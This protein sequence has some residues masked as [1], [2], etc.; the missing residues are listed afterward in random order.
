MADIREIPTS[1]RQ[2]LA[3]LLQGHSAADAM[4]AYYALEHPENKVR[5]FTYTS[6]KG[7]PR[8]FLALAKTGLDL[9]RPLLVPFV[10][11]REMLIELLREVLEPGQPFVLSLPAEQLAWLGDH[12]EFDRTQMYEL[13]RLEPGAYEPVMNVLVVEANSPNGTVRY[14]IRTAEGLRAAAGVNWSGQ[15]Y[16]EVYLEASDAARG[17]GLTKSVLSAMVGRLLGQRRIALYKVESERISVKTEAFRLG[18]R[19]TGQRTVMAEAV[20]LSD[21]RLEA[22]PT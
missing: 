4:A 13:L 6:N 19:P 16:A 11:R 7:D 14:E 1:E 20:L 3:P 12:V 2:Q 18:F 21:P 15:K 8:G 10:G 22:D 5:L 17:R 9:F